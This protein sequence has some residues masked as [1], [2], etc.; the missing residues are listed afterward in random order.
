ME[1]DPVRHRD[2]GLRRASSITRWIAAASAGAAAL[3]A[4]LAAHPKTQASGTARV[5]TD[6]GS[7]ASTDSGTAANSD[8][9]NLD[10][11]NPGSD[12]VV[13]PAAPPVRSRS[14]AQVVTGSS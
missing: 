12:A 1:T 11:A 13:A 10:P 7:R 8:Q 14:H 9:S 5:S 3:F 6:P 4:V 2:S